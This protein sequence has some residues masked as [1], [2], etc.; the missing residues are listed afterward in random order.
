VSFQDDRDRFA[1]RATL[2]DSVHSPRNPWCRQRSLAISAAIA[3]RRGDQAGYEALM[4][5]ARTAL[6]DPVEQAD[7]RPPLDFD[8]ARRARS[9]SPE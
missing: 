6:T 8:A 7:P 9:A 2:R 3:R 1:L 4:A 5:K